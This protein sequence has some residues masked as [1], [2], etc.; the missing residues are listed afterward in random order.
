MC[1]EN[2]NFTGRPP[3][4]E[5]VEDC[6]EIISRDDAAV[7]AGSAGYDIAPLSLSGEAGDDGDRREEQE[8][9]EVTEE[10]EASEEVDESDAVEEV[11]V[12]K[13]AWFVVT[14]FIIAALSFA[15]LVRFFPPMR[16]FL[17]EWLGIG[18][19]AATLLTMMF[20]EPIFLLLGGG[21]W[22]K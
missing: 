20:W 7:R 5:S 12:T 17:M 6:S 15:G 22:R 14:W 13:S 11:P 18:K 9:N 4:T 3:D 16:D 2:S 1:T 19:P 21:T 8:E 10:D